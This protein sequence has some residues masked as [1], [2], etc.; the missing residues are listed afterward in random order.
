[1]NL[2]SSRPVTFCGTHKNSCYIHAWPV[3]PSYH[4]HHPSLASA[5][6]RFHLSAWSLEFS[7][8]RSSSSTASAAA[9]TAASAVKSS[10]PISSTMSSLSSSPSPVALLASNSFAFPSPLP[11]EISLLC[12]WEYCSFATWRFRYLARPIKINSVIRTSSGVQIAS[13]DS[14]GNHLPWTF[15]KRCFLCVFE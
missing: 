2:S 15:V 8:S 5:R 10:R 1:M 12:P 7:C 11:S 14:R 4:H 13:M 3:P 9:V 6:D